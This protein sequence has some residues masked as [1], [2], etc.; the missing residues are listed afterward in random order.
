MWC[1]TI[2]PKVISF[3]LWHLTWGW[4]QLVINSLLEWFFLIVMTPFTILHAAMY[5]IFLHV[6]TTA[7]C[8]ASIGIYTMHCHIDIQ[9]IQ[10]YVVLY[11]DIQRV[12]I[13]FALGYNTIMYGIVLLMHPLI[14]V[15]RFRLAV[16]LLL[17][18]VISALLV[19]V[20]IDF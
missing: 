2:A 3:L 20:F 13:P 19:P 6:F 18:A 8:I 12:T 9:S 15:M 16:I 7:V 4:R 1:I 17:S 10:E 11:S 5:T 14:P